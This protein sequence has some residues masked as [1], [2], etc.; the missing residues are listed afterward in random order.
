[1]RAFVPLFQSTTFLAFINPDLW[2]NDDGDFSGDLVIGFSTL[3]DIFPGGEGNGPH[4]TIFGVYAFVGRG[5]N[6]IDLEFDSTDGGPA[7]STETGVVP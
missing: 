1:M 4:D 3:E 7:T 5:L 2:V 6:D